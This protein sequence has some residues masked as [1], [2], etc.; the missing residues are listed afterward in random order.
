MQEEI[1][2]SVITVGMN[3]LPFIKELYHSLFDNAETRPKA[4]FEAIY[5]DNCSTD[6]SVEY[7]RKNYPQVKIFV[8]KKSKGFGSNNNFGVSMSQGKYLALINPDIVL[9]ENA[10]DNLLNY[11]ER[12]ITAGIVVPKLL[13]TDLS[14]QYSIRSFISLK[15]LFYRIIY[16]GKDDVSNKEIN[17][18]LQK[19]IDI[20]AIQSIDWA[21]GAAFFLSKE[22]FEALR[23]FDED[24]FLYVEDE[25]LCLR[26]W[27]MQRQV[28][29][30][31]ESQMI[32][33]H[34]RASRKVGKKM[35]FHIKSM[36][37]FFLKHGISVKSYK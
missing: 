35:F 10:I 2:V 37:L 16:K 8:N 29:Y 14:V 21:I 12:N 31:P 9:L 18:Y 7:I 11:I 15:M 6:E 26:I 30:V 4:S 24:Y 5:V 3:H 36:I 32:H 28:I 13:N 34:L 33:N 20:N 17:N 25:D 23:G 22:L 27:K 1:K 19:N